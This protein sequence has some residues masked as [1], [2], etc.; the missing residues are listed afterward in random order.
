MTTNTIPQITQRQLLKMGFTRRMIETLLPAPTLVNN[1]FFKH[2]APMKLWDKSAV[3]A[4]KETVAFQEY[5]GT[6]SY[7][8]GIPLSEANRLWR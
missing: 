4:A 3:D 2:G 6:P 5:I 8:N 1:P 7:K